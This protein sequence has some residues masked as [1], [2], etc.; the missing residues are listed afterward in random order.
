VTVAPTDKLGVASLL[1]RNKL[2][3]FRIARV[4]KK[5]GLVSADLTLNTALYGDQEVGAVACLEDGVL[6][7][8][9]IGR[10]A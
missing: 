6:T 2:R 1:R 8:L 9:Y 7:E 4:K 10:V 3:H 5:D